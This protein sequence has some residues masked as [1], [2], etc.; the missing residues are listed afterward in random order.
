LRNLI[1]KKMDVGSS[2]TLELEKPQIS[3]LAAIP[4]PQCLNKS[5]QMPLHYFAIQ[6][7]LLGV[8]QHSHAGPFALRIPDRLVQLKPRPHGQ[9]FDV[10]AKAS[11]A[12]DRFCDH[13]G[14][15]ADPDPNISFED[16][17]SDHSG[18]SVRAD[19]GG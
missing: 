16:V 15:K 2:S 11:H 4:P 13:P 5:V 6:R 14:A 12:P 18:D 17:Y 10:P 7:E 1:E 9:R 8:G 3:H 19:M